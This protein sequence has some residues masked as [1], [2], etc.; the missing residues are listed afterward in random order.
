MASKEDQQ[1]LLQK[2]LTNQMSI[3]QRH[4]MSKIDEVLD[5]FYLVCKICYEREK[6]G[7]K[8]KMIQIEG[9]GHNWCEECI[10]K[11]TKFEAEKGQYPPRCEDNDVPVCT[12]RLGGKEF[13]LEISELITKHAV[14]DPIYCSDPSCATYLRPDQIVFERKIALCARCTRA[15]CIECKRKFHE[16]DCDP[17]DI[18]ALIIFAKENRLQQCG[19]CA[20]FID[21]NGGCIHIS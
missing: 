14:P 6:D 3:F 5:E 9:C 4:M 15:T 10:V 7:R 11:C 19:S 21:R 17:D 20:R 16:G 18:A 1:Q 13:F 12:V 8:A 2:E